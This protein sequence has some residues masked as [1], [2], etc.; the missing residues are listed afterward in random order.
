MRI[1]NCAV[2]GALLLACSHASANNPAAV[3]AAQTRGRWTSPPDT[4][5]PARARAVAEALEAIR[6]R[7][8]EPAG[9]VYQ[10]IHVL[11]GVPAGR[12]LR[13]MDHGYSRSLGVGCGHCHVEGDWE[14]EDSTRK[15]VA[16][17]MIRMVRHINT[18][19]LAKIEGLRSDT[20]IV[21]CTTCHRGT[22]KPA[23][24]LDEPPRTAG[25]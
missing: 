9:S 24:D 3:P 10:E 16:R 7:E 4:A 22:T 2:A 21:N 15:E 18:E 23:L 1:G 20:A 6:G 5:A 25:H 8:E 12:L 17:E 11:N 13:I 14:R 19:H